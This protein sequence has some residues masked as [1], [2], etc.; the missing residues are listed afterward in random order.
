MEEIKN[1]STV[2]ADGGNNS[3]V[4][5]SDSTTNVAVADSSTTTPA[6]PTT[7]GATASGNPSAV[8]DP[9]HPAQMEVDL[10][11]QTPLATAPRE[12]LGSSAPA[13]KPR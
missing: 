4:Q 13:R 8:A 2:V 9:V 3:T 7:T 1:E 5:P 11:L 12:E 6:A 10:P